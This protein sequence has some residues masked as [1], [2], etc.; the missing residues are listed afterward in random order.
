MSAVGF[1]RMVERL[2]ETP[3]MASPSHP[4]LLRH[5]TYLSNGSSPPPAWPWNA[6]KRTDAPDV[7]CAVY[8][9]I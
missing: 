2:G 6:I 4:H 8:L 5:S 9:R 3:K 7:P 1:R